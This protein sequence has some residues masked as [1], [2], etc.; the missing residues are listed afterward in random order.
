MTR[1]GGDFIQSD[2]PILASV[3]AFDG[4]GVSVGVRTT[5]KAGV[6]PQVIVRATVGSLTRNND[7]DVKGSDRAVTTLDGALVIAAAGFGRVAI[8]FDRNTFFNTNGV[9]SDLTRFDNARYAKNLFEWLASIDAGKPLVLSA[10]FG[11]EFS[12]HRI[13]FAFNT[14]VRASLSV[15]DIS[16]KNLTTGATFVPASVAWDASNRAAYFQ[17]SSLLPDGSYT[18]TL[19]GAGVSDGAG[20]LPGDV[21]YRFFVL[22]ADANRDRAVDTIDLNALAMNFGQSSRGFGSGNFDY[23]GDGRVSTTD[24]NFLAGNF[25][26]IQSAPAAGPA[27]MRAEAPDF[28][29]LSDE[30]LV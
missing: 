22:N 3:N 12:P 19:K 26:K 23:S 25:G 7:N 15:S 28:T 9:G 1:A 29:R 8:T 14:D 13:R 6:T 2:H 21:V 27:T 20:A 30:I 10:D 11:Y 18:A 5:P 4:E 24:F 16:V 17:F